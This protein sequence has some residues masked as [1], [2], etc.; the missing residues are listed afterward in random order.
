MEA[1]QE[2]KD[3]LDNLEQQT[4]EILKDI[5][6]RRAITVDEAIKLYQAVT[7]LQEV[8]DNIEIN[9]TE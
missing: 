3:N 9:Y 4:R 5:L 6:S 1:L 7:Q 8:A 2:L